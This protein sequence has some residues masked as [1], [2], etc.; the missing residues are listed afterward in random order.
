MSAVVTLRNAAV[1]PH[2]AAYGPFVAP[3]G[4]NFAIVVF[5]SG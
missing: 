3:I 1:T 5:Y 2:I 4:D